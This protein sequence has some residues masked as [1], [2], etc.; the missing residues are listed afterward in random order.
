MRLIRGLAEVRKVSVGDGDTQSV[1]VRDAGRF[2]RLA[3]STSSF[4]ADL[5]PDEA[6]EI[7]NQ[8]SLAAKRAEAIS[9]TPER[10]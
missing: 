7:A 3:L 6:H 1:T 5:T 4:P 8:L 10:K 2:V 9:K